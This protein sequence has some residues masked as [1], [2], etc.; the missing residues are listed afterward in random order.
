[1]NRKKSRHWNDCTQARHHR[2]RVR[3]E[4]TGP[5][6]NMCTWCQDSCS[7]ISGNSLGHVGVFLPELALIFCFHSHA[8]EPINSLFFHSFPGLSLIMW[9]GLYTAEKVIIQW[10][11]LSEACYFAVQFL[12]EF[13]NTDYK[14]SSSCFVSSFSAS[15]RKRMA[16]F[17]HVG[18]FAE[19]KMCR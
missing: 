4:S 18:V 12:G 9:N 3:A 5:V 6:S 8:P 19:R 16:T 11:L 14:L 15:C 10:T 2:Q 1:M 13:S 17:V 7:F